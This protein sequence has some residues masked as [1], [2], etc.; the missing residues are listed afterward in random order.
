MKHRAL[1]AEKVA[2]NAV[3]AGCLPADFPV[4][5][6]ATEAMCK[7]EFLLHG[8][9]ASTGACAVLLVVSGPIRR[10]LEMSSTHSVLAGP[11]RASVCFMPQA[12]RGPT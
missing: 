6:D 4:V 5:A 11:D 3:L 8:A 2:V 12:G 1:T 7:P 10:Q 9:T